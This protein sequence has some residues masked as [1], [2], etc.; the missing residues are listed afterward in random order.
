MPKP[1]ICIGAALVDE[2]FH[3]TETILNATTNNAHV[4]KTA[5]G[6]ARNIA[7]QLALL[8]VPVQLISVFGNDSDGHWLKQVCTQA[9]VQLDG[10][11]TIEGLSGKY[12]GIL[13][14]DGSLY[15]AFLTNAAIQLISPSHLQQQRALLQ[16]AGYILADANVSVETM[17]WLLSFSKETGIPFI[18]EPVSVPPA[19]KLAALQLEG[20]YLVTPNEDEL[21]VMCGD[22]SSSTKKQVEEL[23][24]RGVQ[25]IWLHNG[26]HGSSIVSKE[27]TVSLHASLVEV[28][29][30]T[31]AGDGSLSGYLLGKHLGKEDLDCLKIAHS[32]SA[33]I[34]QVNGAIA[35]HL[36]REQLLEL[37]PKY[38]PEA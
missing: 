7:H 34:L 20:L 10:S 9:G 17:E 22:E 30:C 1:I 3:A 38:F 27:K 6:V 2:L 25:Q 31:G 29:D 37:V 13:D 14:R 11:V 12:T 23:L 4:T 15:T 32:L 24:N 8:G 33:E 26:I 28:V 5:G 21:P 36:N 19:S 16:T 18:I 35:T